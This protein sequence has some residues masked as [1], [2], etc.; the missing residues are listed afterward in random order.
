[1]PVG[2]SANRRFI[3]FRKRRLVSL[4]AVDV[5]AAS[6]SVHCPEGTRIRVSGIARLDQELCEGVK[7]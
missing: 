7:R 5:I 3:K 1:M 2:F 6:G 4:N